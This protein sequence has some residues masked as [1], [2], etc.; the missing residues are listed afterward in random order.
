MLFSKRLLLSILIGT[1]LALV[2]R[3][4]YD[5]LPRGLQIKV[6]EHFKNVTDDEIERWI[7]DALI[8]MVVGILGS[9]YVWYVIWQVQWSAVRLILR[10][11]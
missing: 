8:L 10:Y 1:L 3:V 2:F 7:V 6:D 5:A 11:P 9:L 4:V